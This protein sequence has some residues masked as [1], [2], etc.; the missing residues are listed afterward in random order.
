MAFL[1]EESVFTLFTAS[2]K[3]P[4][5]STQE[6][7]GSQGLCICRSAPASTGRQLLPSA[8][9]IEFKKS[10]SL[11]AGRCGPVMSRGIKSQCF[12][13]GFLW[14]DRPGQF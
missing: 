8:S 11:L 3:S 14:V 9:Y 13:Q 2:S 10:A 7:L 5:A 4:L 1:T 12:H 6:P